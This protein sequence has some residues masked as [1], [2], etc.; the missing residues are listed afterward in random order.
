[1]I[2]KEYLSYESRESCYKIHAT[3]WQPKLKVK[4]I[5]I[6]AHGM[7]EY[8]DRYDAF[9]TYLAEHG[10]LVAGCDYIGHGKTV[11]G[12]DKYGYFCSRDP[13]TVVVRDVHRLKK[14]I[15]ERYPCIPQIVMGH[16]MG[17]FVILNY[18]YRYGNGVDGAIFM[19]C[20]MPSKILISCSRFIANLQARVVGADK[21][22]KLLNRLAFGKYNKKVTDPESFFSWLSFNKENVEKYDNDP[23]C[24][25][26]FTING[27][28]TMLELISRLQKPDNLAQ[29]PKDMKILMVSGAM[30]PVCEYGKGF[31]KVE[32]SL[33]KVG[34]ND[35]TAKLY[36]WGRHEILQEDEKKE[37]FEDI[38]NWLDSM[39]T[40]SMGG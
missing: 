16:S 39:F 26:I 27:F 24:G 22:G 6:I 11:V 38:K 3:I 9:A 18:L 21:P 40:V 17:F 36:S 37:V 34:I 23:L 1:M 5:L 31:A 25:F 30:D 35:I 14:T 2:S 19:G 20:G 4:A 7:A 28:Q 13:A 15:Q 32:K 12:F 8:I 10:I 29:I 33:R